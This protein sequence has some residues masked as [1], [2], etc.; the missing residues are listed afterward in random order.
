MSGLWLWGGEV[1]FFA[2]RDW[3]VGERVGKVGLLTWE[4]GDGTRFWGEVLG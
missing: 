2:G 1:P 3:A 4:D